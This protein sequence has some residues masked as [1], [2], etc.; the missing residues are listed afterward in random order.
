MT[1]RFSLLPGTLNL[2]TINILLTK[3]MTLAL[4]PSALPSIYAAQELVTKV[5]NEKKTIYGINTGF[6]SLAQ[7]TISTKDLLRLQRNLVLSHA[8]GTG[9]LLS[10]EIVS[11][12]LLL[13][14]N[15]LAQGYSGVSKDLIDTLITFFN[16]GI[17]PCIPAKGSVGA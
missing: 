3:K 10:D 9:E 11:L 16:W 4:D 7:Q 5:V 14:I 2:E 17:Y 15:C 8:C 12:I 1:E 6:G 13:K